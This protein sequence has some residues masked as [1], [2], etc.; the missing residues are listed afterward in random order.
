MTD[1]NN[2]AEKLNIINAKKIS[3][4]NIITT[5][6]LI[7]LAVIMLVIA[8]LNTYVFFLVEV[9]GESMLPTLN[10]G[11]VVFV[12]KKLVAK[13]EAI[14]IIDGEKS[15]SYLIKRVIATGGDTVEIKDGYVF[16]NGEK[17]EEEYV[18]KDGVTNKM[19]EKSKW[20][21]TEDEIFYLGD[22]RINSRDSRDDEYGTC[23]VEQ[24]VGVVE[25]WSIEKQKL[26]RFLYSLGR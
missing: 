22:N 21:L 16:I 7:V 17:L 24:I 15:N 19:G 13:R 9:S 18:I 2:L 12:N 6:L 5:I 23:K 1:D 11:D 14:I 26:N 25:E 4:G 10:S 3:V 20:M 8:Y